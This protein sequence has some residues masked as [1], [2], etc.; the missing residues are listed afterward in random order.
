MKDWN[1]ITVDRYFD[2]IKFPVKVGLGILD[3]SRDIPSEKVR[4]R[5]FDM[6]FWMV[7]QALK[8]GAG[9]YRGYKEK[10]EDILQESLDNKD[11]ICVI[12]CQGMMSHRLTHIISCSI[13]YFKVNP[14]RFV[15]GHIMARPER[16]PGLHRQ[17]LI[18]NLKV[19]EKLGKPAFLECGFFWDRKPEYRNFVLSENKVVAE[20]TPEWIGPAFGKSKYEYT[21]DGANWIDLALK[22]NIRIDNLSLDIRECKTFIYPYEDTAILEKVWHNLSDEESI[23]KIKNYSTRSWIRKLSYQNTIEKDRVYAFNTER[24]S[25]EGIRSPGPVDAL[26]SAAAGFKPLAL[27]RNNQF[28]DNT[29][30]HYYDWCDASLKFKKHLLETWDGQDFHLWLLE[31]DLVYNFASTYRGTYEEFWKTEIDKEFESE[32]KFKELWDRYKSLNHYFHIID[33]VNNPEQLFDLISQYS[34]NRVLWTTNIWA[35][36]MLHWNT[37]PEELEK[38]WLKFESLIPKDLVLYGQDYLARDM[39]FRLNSKINITHPRY[40][41]E[42]KYI[43]I[44]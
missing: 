13:E 28:H 37:E 18:V 17:L 20:Y 4:K 35:S 39:T 33:I 38:K 8:I 22:N 44:S 31:N 15:L 42:N 29:V 9:I 23:N 26:F 6:T 5:T 21:E 14:E 16:Y 30:V 10:V 25:A 11:E 12:Q 2:D 24:L 32:E 1:S 7:N 19:W 41:T 36:M 34:G 40:N 3:I 43:H 27:L